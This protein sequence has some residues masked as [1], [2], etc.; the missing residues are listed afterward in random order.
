MAVTSM[1]VSTMQLQLLQVCRCN[2]LQRRSSEKTDL[3]APDL[4]T[5]SSTHARLARARL[6]Q[7]QPFCQLL[8][9]FRALHNVLFAPTPTG[10][11]T[12]QTS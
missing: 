1:P 8:R 6:L 10:A 2:L 9:L 11:R 7:K 5:I 3:I 12:R 4:P